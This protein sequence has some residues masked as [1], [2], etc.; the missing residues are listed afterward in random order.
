MFLILLTYKKPL[1]EVDQFL[2]GHNIHLQKYYQQRIF[3]CSGPQVPR[4]GGVIVCRAES[5]EV[6]ERIVQEDPFVKHG[7]A[8]YSIIQFDPVDHLP[9]FAPFI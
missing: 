7:V 2:P 6:V 8:E 4:S 3:I 9:D 1:A 5:K